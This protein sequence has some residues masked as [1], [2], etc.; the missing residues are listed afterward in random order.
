MNDLVK[1]PDSLASIFEQE[2][3]SLGS[4]GVDEMALPLHAALDAIAI[5]RISCTAAKGGEVWEKVGDRFKPTYDG[6]NSEREDYSSESEYIEAALL[7]KSR[8]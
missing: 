8:C 3:I 7:H 5:L 6:W 2:G 1:I 4:E